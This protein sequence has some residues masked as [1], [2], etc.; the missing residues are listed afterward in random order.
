MSEFSVQQQKAINEYRSKNNLG[1]VISDAEV[2]SIMQK[3]MKKTGKIYPGFESLATGKS[4]STDNKSNVFGT[5]F[6]SA[7]DMGVSVEKSCPEVPHP[8]ISPTPAQQFT[9][10]FLKNITGD[11]KD[12]VDQREKEAGVLSS[13]VNTW[14][15]IF[16]KELAKSTITKE[17][18][19]AQDDI[20]LLEAAANGRSVNKNYFTGETNSTSFEE[21]FKKRRGVDFNEEAI[22]DCD[23]KSNTFARVKTASEMINTIKSELAEA[24]KGDVTSQM[25]PEK[26]SAA[27]V[28]A[29]NLSGLT[30][31]KDMN[32]VL[33][34]I[35]EKYKDN[36]DIKKFGGNLRLEK[37]HK[38]SR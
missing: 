27:I 32:A 34:Q 36:P 15:E 19:T 35:E 24:T 12:I 14:K 10:D 16:D 8:R 17:I 18:K 11:A 38:V 25:N 9:I 37:I 1:Y 2:A 5:G 30:K 29:F 13:V 28:K 23:E 22:A 7:D 26:S 20:M 4:G 21:M 6:N 31:A 3:E 33:K